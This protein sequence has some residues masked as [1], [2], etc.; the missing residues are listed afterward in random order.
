MAS[1]IYNAN[2]ISHDKTK[3]VI[4]YRLDILV[5]IAL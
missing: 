4:L 3:L 1:D 5:Q 2:L